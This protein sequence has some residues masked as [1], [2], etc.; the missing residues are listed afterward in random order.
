MAFI[1]IPFTFAIIYWIK[2]GFIFD[3]KT[4]LIAVYIIVNVLIHTWVT[5]L[6][7]NRTNNLF[8]IRAINFVDI[9]F[10]G[11][12]LLSL[13]LSST[14]TRI[15]IT[16]LLL[17]AIFLIDQGLGVPK[18]SPNEQT[19]AVSI[20]LILLV[21]LTTKKINYT[22]EKEKAYSYFIIAIVIGAINNLSS[23]FS[24]LLPELFLIILGTANI[25]SYTF[26]TLGFH[27]LIKES[28]NQINF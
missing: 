19:S 14:Q 18:T 23:N 28:K 20:I 6:A 8:L 15:I 24:D 3:Q 11:L 26:F 2:R 12:F 21:I 1:L 16:L 27:R 4:N 5:Y 22:E 17:S 10:I 13:Y 25:T 7:F 9:S